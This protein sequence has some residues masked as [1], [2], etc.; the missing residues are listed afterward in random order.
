[1]TTIVQEMQNFTSLRE[2]A[3]TT[4]EQQIEN[5]DYYS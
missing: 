4:Y 2:A 3:A 1:M 5:M